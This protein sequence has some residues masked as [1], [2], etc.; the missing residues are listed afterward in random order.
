MMLN[1]IV[2]ILQYQV[3]K[4]QSST[5]ICQWKDKANKHLWIIQ[6]CIWKKIML[7]DCFKVAGQLSEL[8]VHTSD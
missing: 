4:K 6:A 1:D 2:A 5:Q 7:N 8:K 3:T